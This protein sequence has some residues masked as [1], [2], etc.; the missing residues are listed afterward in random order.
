MQARYNRDIK[1]GQ[2]VA[3]FT[4]GAIGVIIVV[5]TVAGVFYNV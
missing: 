3:G 1:R 5:L 2:R 4:W